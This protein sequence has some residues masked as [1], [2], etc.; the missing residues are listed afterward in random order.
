ML[1]TWSD[2]QQCQYRL[3]E[4][5]NATTIDSELF[6]GKTHPLF[7]VSFFDRTGKTT[8]ALDSLHSKLNEQ[9]S[10]KQNWS[11]QCL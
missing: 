11:L 7:I 10:A 1:D 4:F 8:I 5:L 6:I 3:N 9:S 2:S